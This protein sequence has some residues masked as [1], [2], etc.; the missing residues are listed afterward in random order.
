MVIK[1]VKNITPN[2]NK[3]TQLKTLQ[4][5]NVPTNQDRRK[6]PEVYLNAL[7]HPQQV[8]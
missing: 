2:T 5:N 4:K 3:T 7:E 6:A 1:K 8:S